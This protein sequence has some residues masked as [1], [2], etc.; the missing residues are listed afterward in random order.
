MT[1]DELKV[2]LAE[3]RERMSALAKEAIDLERQIAAI[4]CPFSI[5]DVVEFGWPRNR[6]KAK[7]TGI[8]SKYGRWELI[9]QNVRKDGSLGATV[10][11]ESIHSPVKVSA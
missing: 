8:T 1:I 3:V 6:R 5:G 11:I 2:R 10:S 9:A 4:N 7:V